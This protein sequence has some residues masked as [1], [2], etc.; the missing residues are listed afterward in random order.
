MKKKW[1]TLIEMLIV[2]AIIGIMMGITINFWANR[3]QK[4]RYQSSKAQFVNSYEKLQSEVLTTN[5]HYRQHFDTF[6]IK[7]QSDLNNYSY[8]Y[9]PI[10]K[11]YSQKIE[12]HVQIQ[13]IVFLNNSEKQNLEQA[14]LV[15]MPYQLPCK[16]LLD[17]KL[18]EEWAIQFELNILEYAKK[19]CFE[20]DLNN[21]KLIEK[22]EWICSNNIAIIKDKK[23][24]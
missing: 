19:Y 7:F 5:Y 9:Q 12:D 23:E 8:E 15:L 14:E 11:K 3:I 10:Q 2:I 21:C 4:L 22:K 16:L 13:N 1:F 17:G 24:D 6:H 18:Q 20:I